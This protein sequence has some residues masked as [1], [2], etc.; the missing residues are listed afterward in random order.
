MT[1]SV[2]KPATGHKRHKNVGYTR[3]HTSTHTHSLGLACRIC[4]FF[5]L[6]ESC[7]IVFG[8]CCKAE[9]QTA[10]VAT[11]DAHILLLQLSGD[12]RL[13]TGALAPP[14]A[15]PFIPPLAPPADG[16]VNWRTLIAFGCQ[17]STT[18]SPGGL[19]DQLMSQPK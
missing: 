9:K 1:K 2:R 17:L 3:A 6:F 18:I 12:R 14:T 5:F 7:S 13:P 10:A 11:N 19:T 8:L 15:P 16:A 4:S